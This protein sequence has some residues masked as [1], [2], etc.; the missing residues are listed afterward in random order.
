MT[1]NAQKAMTGLLKA[2]IVLAVLLFVPAWSL[3]F[4]EGW[5]YLAIMTA[6]SA[7]IILY[8]ARH[9][10]ALIGRRL[11]AGP[12]AEKEK[13]QKIIQGLTSV[14]GVILYLVPG[15]DARWHW[16]QVPMA[17]VV[18]GQI[19]VAL[20]F[21]ITFL[22][23]RENTYASSI[24]EVAKDQKVISSGPYAIVRHP[25]Y[26]GVVLLFLATPLALNSWWAFVPAIALSTMIAVRLI[27]EEK[28]LGAN[29]SGYAD[30]RLSVRSRLIPG[31]W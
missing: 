5:V 31:I 15:F 6:C 1:A 29:L 12:V 30:Y 24:V 9:D 16:S 2:M 23:F 19:G 10:D 7:A 18:I 14:F 8:L 11:K 22:V 13:S 3:R 17:L 27:D 26:A 4:R 20:G 21:L 25:M 28:F